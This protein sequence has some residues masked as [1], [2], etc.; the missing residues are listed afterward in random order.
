MPEL[1]QASSLNFYRSIAFMSYLIL[2]HL[3]KNNNNP[4]LVRELFSDH[5]RGTEI[6]IASRDE[7]SAIF[8]IHHDIKTNK[9]AVRKKING[10]QQ[11]SLF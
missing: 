4:E 2:S 3:S 1:R 9:Q 6:I 11:L 5:A 10:Q 8:Y 7:A